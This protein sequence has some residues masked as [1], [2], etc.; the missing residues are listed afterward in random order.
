M[1]CINCGKENMLYQRVPEKT[2]GWAKAI[3]ILFFP[4]G[5]IA[6]SAKKPA[7]NVFYCDNCGYETERNC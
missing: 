4:I 1:K 3:A 6:L 7:K 5:L 2:P